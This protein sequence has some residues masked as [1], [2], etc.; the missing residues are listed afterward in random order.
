MMKSIPRLYDDIIALKRDFRD[1]AAISEHFGHGAVAGLQ[2]PG[3]VFVLPAFF[4]KSGGGQPCSVFS[5]PSPIC[6]SGTWYNHA[7]YFAC[8]ALPMPI[9]GAWITA[10]PI[11]RKA[12]IIGLMC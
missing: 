4:L 8:P 9:P 12:S 1:N 3:E 5:A 2:R 7:A 6:S 11:R 10:A